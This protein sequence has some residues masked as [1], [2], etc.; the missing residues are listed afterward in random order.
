MVLFINGLPLSVIELK[1]A[2]DENAM[3]WSAFNPRQTDKQQIPTLFT[4][5]AALVISDGGQARIGTLETN[6]RP[7]P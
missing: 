7:S 6:K 4:W 5:N 1:Y 3:N 2:T